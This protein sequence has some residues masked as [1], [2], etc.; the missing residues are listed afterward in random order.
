MVIHGYQ[1]L[2]ANKP[3]FLSAGSVISIGNFDGL[4]LGHRQ[5][6][7]TAKTMAESKRLPWV[8]YTFRPHPVQ[9]LKP[10]LRIPLIL[11]YPEKIELLQKLG[12]ESGLLKAI[13]EE[14]FSREFSNLEAETFFNEALVGVLNVKCIVVGYN[15][16]FGKDRHGNLKLL[17][18]LCKDHQVQLEIVPAFELDQQ[19]VSSSNIR[20]FLSQSNV[21][22]AAVILGSQFFYRG[23][24]ER[25]DGRG[26]TIGFP[27]ANV[28]VPKFSDDGTK[29]VL[30]YGVYSTDCQ[31]Q[32]KVYASITNLG[33]RPTIKNAHPNEPVVLMETHLLDQQ[34][35]LYGKRIEVQ[36]KKFIRPEQKFGSLD[37]LVAQIQLDVKSVR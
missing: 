12:S 20:A 35:D 15:F 22:K 24:V 19:G 7:K 31:V 17:A 13:I 14:P 34:I 1:E 30:P 6:L 11:T 2:K 32:D 4:H 18:K 28:W 23:I 16:N 36:F 26:R 9:A 3:A 29:I 21:Q 5:I 27:T 25:G 8:V 10:E 33:V 37:E